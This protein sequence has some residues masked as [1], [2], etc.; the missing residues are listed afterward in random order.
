MTGAYDDIIN[1]PHH[2]STT[3]PHMSAIDR[4]AQFSPFAALTGYDAAVKETA[5]L[6]DDKI[7]LD[8]SMK[9]ALSDQLQI[10]ADRIKEYPE[11]TITYFQPDEKKNGG[12]YVAVT[13]TVKKIDK[14]E[15]VVV[16]TDGKAIPID[17]IIRIDGQLFKTIVCESD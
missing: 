10:I 13:G 9:E 17:E 12:A 5:R 6:T 2:V 8:E 11:I 7:E 15:R 4:A 14:Y 16:M 1:L 3:H